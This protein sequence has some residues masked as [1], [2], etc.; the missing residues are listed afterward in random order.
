MTVLI[1]EM[2]HIQITDDIYG[3]YVETKELNLRRS[4][5]EAL[6]FQIDEILGDKA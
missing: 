2:F 4:D 1:D 6:R 3:G 5:L